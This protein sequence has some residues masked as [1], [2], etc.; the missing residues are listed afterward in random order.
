MSEPW[1][2]A[3]GTLGHVRDSSASASSVDHRLQGQRHVGPGVAV[4]HG[5]DVEAVDRLLVGGRA[6]RYAVDHGREVAGSRGAPASAC[7]GC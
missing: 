7:A 4:G 2:M 1:L 5:V 6:S 3:C